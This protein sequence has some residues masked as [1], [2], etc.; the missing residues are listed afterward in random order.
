M[1]PRIPAMSFFPSPEPLSAV[2]APGR[3]EQ[4]LLRAAGRGI[5]TDTPQAWSIDDAAAFWLPGWQPPSRE[6]ETLPA[7]GVMGLAT[8]A[9]LSLCRDLPPIGPLFASLSKLPRFVRPREYSPYEGVSPHGFCYAA[10]LAFAPNGQAI[11]EQLHDT[12]YR[13]LAETQ[14]VRCDEPACKES[15]SM[16]GRCIP[17]AAFD[18]ARRSGLLL[19]TRKLDASPLTLLITRLSSWR[20]RR[21]YI[22]VRQ[23]TT[24][25][26]CL[27]A[28]YWVYDAI[29][30]L[31]RI[32]PA[33]LIDPD[34]QS[35]I[36]FTVARS[37]EEC[38]ANIRKPPRGV[39]HL[40][41]PQTGRH[42]PVTRNRR[43]SVVQQIWQNSGATTFVDARL[44]DPV[45]MW[46]GKKSLF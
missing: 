38:I 11:R 13:T 19:P 25:T 40:P 22:A 24:H 21:P 44:S 43:A 14:A 12:G 27:Y 28:P 41:D 20:T 9:F 29:A 36:R 16:L 18:N 8:R 31:A 46:F 42:T 4:M 23:A 39:L 7:D 35:L 33:L 6:H 3:Y 26:K 1:Q 37:H 30:N 2:P 5:G 15:E 10:H 17:Q 32:L 45:E 34:R